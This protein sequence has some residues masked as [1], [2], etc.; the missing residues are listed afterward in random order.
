M[1]CSDR[2]T[3]GQSSDEFIMILIEVKTTA[4]AISGSYFKFFTAKHKRQLITHQSAN[5]KA[6]LLKS[7]QAEIFGEKLVTKTKNVPGY[8]DKTLSPD[9]KS[10]LCTMHEKE[11]EFYDKLKTAGGYLRNPQA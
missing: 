3:E 5:K 4:F 7:Y 6:R 9:V 10:M 8:A 11:F 2:N 1:W